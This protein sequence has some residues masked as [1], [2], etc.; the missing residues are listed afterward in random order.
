MV[1]KHLDKLQREAAF[2]DETD[3]IALNSLFIDLN[4][5]QKKF[6]RQLTTIVVGPVTH[7]DDDLSVSKW[8][9]IPSNH[10]CISTLFMAYF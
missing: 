6:Q 1:D 5:S 7:P 2:F 4:I 9:P 10:T 3:L 8:I